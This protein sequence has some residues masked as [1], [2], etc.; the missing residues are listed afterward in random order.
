MD[1]AVPVDHRIKVNEIKKFG[2]IPGLC[3]RS[4]K[5]GKLEKDSD[6]N[7]NQN[8]KDL[9]NRLKEL[10]IRGRI[11]TIQT[12]TLLKSARII[13]RVLET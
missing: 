2:K 10:K 11:E 8:S 13:R 4:G 6:T 5:F 1:F 9:E 7:H 12:T 3:Q